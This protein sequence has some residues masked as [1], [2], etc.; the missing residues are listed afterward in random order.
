M[1]KGNGELTCTIDRLENGQAV[2]DFGS[3]G[4]LTLA[5]KHLPKT[6]KEGD[7]L[8][9]ELLTDQAATKRRENLARAILEEILNSPSP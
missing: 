4:S 2:L 1:A 6:A 5:K 8:T 9:V 7:A 3:Y